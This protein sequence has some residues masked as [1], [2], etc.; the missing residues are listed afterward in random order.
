MTWVRHVWRPGAASY[1]GHRAE[2][3]N[4][5]VCVVVDEAGKMGMRVPL[6]ILDLTQE[7]YCLLTIEGLI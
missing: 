7:D 2:G 4:T 5:L 6:P 1:S 3:G